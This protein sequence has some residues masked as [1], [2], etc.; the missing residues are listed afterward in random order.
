MSREEILEKM[1]DIFRQVFNNDSIIV[2]NESTDNDI[3]EWTSLTFMQLIT[4]Q[5]SVFNIKYTLKDMLA[6]R[7]VGDMVDFIY[8]SQK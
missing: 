6:I 4:E 8:N 5:Q 3:E 7:T 1:Q 2:T